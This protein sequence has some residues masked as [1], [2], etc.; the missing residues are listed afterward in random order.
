MF[1]IFDPRNC[2]LYMGCIKKKVIVL[3]DVLWKDQA[4]NITVIVKFQ[5][6]DK[7]IL[8]EISE[9]MLKFNPLCEQILA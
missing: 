6:S 9:N 4:L 5:E 2:E 7:K 8:V 3:W 1:W